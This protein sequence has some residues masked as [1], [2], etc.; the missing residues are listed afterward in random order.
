M[1]GEIPSGWETRILAEL[2]SEHYP[3]DWGQERGVQTA[4][5]IRSTNLTREGR[6]D[7]TDV[8]V[9]ALSPLK[10]SM[11]TPKRGDILLERSGGGPG[12]PVGR[13]GFVERDLPDHAFSNFLH[14]LRP[15]P[16]E[17]NPRF[18]G[19]ILHQI[20][21]TGRVVRLEQQ[22]TQMRNLNFRDYLTMQLPYPPL[23][24]QAAIARILD[25]VDTAIEHTRMVIDHT[26]ELHYCLLHDLLERGLVPNRSK[27]RHPKHWRTVR[28]DEVATVGSGVTLGKDVTGHK[29]VELPY[30]RVANVQDGHLDLT[31]IKT[32]RVLAEEVQKYRL[33]AGDILMTE[34]GDID[35]LGRGT[36]W[37]GQIPICLH[38][39]HIFRIRP[40]RALLEPSFYALV[41][42]SEIAK[43]YFN[44]VAKRTTNLAS[45]NKTQVRAFQFPI[46]PT[47][48]AQR[49]IVEIMTRS[50]SML[51]ELLRKETAMVE[52][53]RSLL[54][55]LL[56]GK[57]RVGDLSVASAS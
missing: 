41:V 6:L 57:V 15:K 52:L 14:L 10:A 24:E 30:L 54:H 51:A 55:D 4:K 21:H 38:Q 32:V 48:S 13:V 25:A 27:G 36:I 26:R 45:T 44:R 47:V 53:K 49:K 56:T 43:R 8:A 3:G 29:S 31:V 37:E 19:W 7:L 1:L 23:C 40:N 9:R 11:L 20:N 17:V 12:Q 28:V 35:K 46:P 16:E 22:T 34:G 2:L 5:I 33:E 42:E 18:L 39:N 50:K